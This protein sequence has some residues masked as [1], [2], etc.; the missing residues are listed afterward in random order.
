MIRP[1]DY[2]LVVWFVLAF[3]SAL[4]VGRDQFR[5]NPEPTVMKWGFIL[6]TLYM[7]PLGWLLYVLADKEPR[8]GEHESF[9]KPLWAQAVRAACAV[10]A[11][12]AVPAV[13]LLLGDAPVERNDSPALLSRL[14]YYTDHR[15]WVTI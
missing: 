9:I 1:V 2:F 3:A 12:D 13:S 6:V 11:V 7:G 4:Y 15:T 14:E 10:A 8:P 5:H